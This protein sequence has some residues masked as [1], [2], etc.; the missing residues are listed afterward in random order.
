MPVAMLHLN[1]TTLFA[2]ASQVGPLWLGYVRAYTGQKVSVSTGLPR[3][4]RVDALAE[5]DEFA[6]RLADMIDDHR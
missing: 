4:E 2:G 3:T 1:G 5:A 6:R